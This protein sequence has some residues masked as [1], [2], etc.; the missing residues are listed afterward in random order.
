MAT[1]LGRPTQTAVMEKL[2]K[3]RCKFKICKIQSQNTTECYRNQKRSTQTNKQTIK[4][5]ISTLQQVIEITVHQGPRT[6]KNKNKTKT[7]TKNKTK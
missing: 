1:R 4:Q 5:V 3:T 6:N 7:K 2:Q